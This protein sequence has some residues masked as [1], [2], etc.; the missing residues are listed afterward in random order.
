[1]ARHVVTAAAE[2]GRRRS[3]V[4]TIGNGLER[5]DS[6]LV[7]GL[8]YVAVQLLPIPIARPPLWDESVYVSQ[9]T[10]GSPAIEFLA[11]RARGS[12]SPSP[13]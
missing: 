9:V 10:P 6:L 4:S 13:S 1:M 5:G 12:R 2:T 8:A 7:V 11:S 3:T